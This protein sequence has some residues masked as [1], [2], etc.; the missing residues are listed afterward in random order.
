MPE[1]VGG[2]DAA[3]TPQPAGTP[4]PMPAPE[5]LQPLAGAPEPE[6]SSP[7]QMPPDLAPPDARAIASA[8]GS[9][10]EFQG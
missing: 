3:L 1:P 8:R 10:D 5:G 4:E 7:G 2:P 9:V 6:G